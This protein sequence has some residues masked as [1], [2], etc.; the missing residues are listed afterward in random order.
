MREARL[1]FGEAVHILAEQIVIKMRDYS[2]MDFNEEEAKDHM[3][4]IES[5]AKILLGC[6]Q[7]VGANN[8]DCA[9]R[10]E[11]LQEALIELRDK[12]SCTQGQYAVIDAALAWS[13]KPAQAKS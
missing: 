6:P 2:S 11:V 7:L 5:V 3:D 13:E 4:D 9:A 8:T 12:T 1:R 10:L